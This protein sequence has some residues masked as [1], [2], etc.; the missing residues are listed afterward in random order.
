[1]KTLLLHPSTKGG[2]FLPMAAQT[3]TRLAGRIATSAKC[4]FDKVPHIALAVAVNYDD[5][6]VQSTRISPVSKSKK[7]YRRVLQ[8][9]NQCSYTGE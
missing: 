3:V 9:L 6:H 4:I 2:L 7:A 5:G 1:M 8:E